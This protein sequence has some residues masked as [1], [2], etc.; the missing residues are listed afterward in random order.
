M[1]FGVRGLGFGTPR[2]EVC[3]FVFVVW[4]FLFQDSY[5]GFGVLC[6]GF[7]VSCFGLSSLETTDHD[8]K[9]EEA[10]WAEQEALFES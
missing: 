1:G 2:F 6:L 5:F 10:I 3:G 4:G 7:G 8:G 9:F